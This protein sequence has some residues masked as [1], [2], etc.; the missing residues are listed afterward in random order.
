QTVD[1]FLQ[2]VRARVLE[3][4][5]FRI[6]SGVTQSERPTNVN[7]R[8]ARFE[9]G[10]RDFVRELIRSR[11]EDQVRIKLRDR[12]LVER[13]TVQSCQSHQLGMNCGERSCLGGTR[14][15]RADQ[16]NLRMG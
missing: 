14:R 2:K 7:N 13:L 4:V 15:E 8:G 16:I 3:A 6:A 12:R 11:E 10:R 5:K 9:Q 1:G